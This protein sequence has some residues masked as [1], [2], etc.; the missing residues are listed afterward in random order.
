NLNTGIYYTSFDMDRLNGYS[1]NYE[2]TA[3][4]AGFDMIYYPESVKNLQVRFRGNFPRDFK[5]TTAGAET[6]WNEYRFILNYN[7]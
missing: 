2:W 7:F 1:A 6:S 5:N 4:E 3:T